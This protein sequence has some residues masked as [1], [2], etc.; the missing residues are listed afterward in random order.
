MKDIKFIIG[1]LVS[2][3]ASFAVTQYVV[4]EA[5]NHIQFIGGPASLLRRRS[6]QE[7][8][9][10]CETRVCNGLAS[11][12]NRAANDIMYA[13]M[14]NA[15]SSRDEG[16]IVPNHSAR[17]EKA[18]DAG[19]RGLFLDSCDC[20]GTEF[21]HGFCFSG[22]RNAKTVFDSIVTFLKGNPNEIVVLELQ[23]DDDT[24]L[25]LWDSASPEFRSF[26]YSHPD[27][28]T[29]WP[30]LNDLIDLQK[31]LIVFQHNGGNCDA[32]GQCPAGVHE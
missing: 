3:L 9:C 10:N 4:L 19:F 16:F 12:C 24:L 30:T 11:N 7:D 25:S 8:C 15:M 17:L 29:P 31:R 14:H 1:V 13:T 20:D 6:L 2:N 22:T 26:L 5:W 28:S 18:L 21:C 27:T 32:Q 23:I